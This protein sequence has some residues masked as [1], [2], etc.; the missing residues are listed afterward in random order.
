MKTD[1]LDRRAP[2]AEPEQ[3]KLPAPVPDG[4]TYFESLGT[5]VDNVMGD[6][7]RRRKSDREL[8][9]LWGREDDAPDDPPP[10]DL[11]D[12]V[13]D[14]SEPLTKGDEPDAEQR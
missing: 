11:P 7:R 6:A 5:L 12:P 3:Q 1:E 13:P 8:A 2:E 10:A 9:P 4:T 14:G